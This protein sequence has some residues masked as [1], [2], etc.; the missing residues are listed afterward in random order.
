MDERTRILVC[1][2]ASVAS[3]CVSCFRH[4]AGKAEAA[5]VDPADVREAVTMGAQVKAGAHAILMAAV[6]A[7]T[8]RPGAAGEPSCC[9]PT[10]GGSCCP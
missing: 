2:S 7:Q 5:G 1:V 4:Y 6:D 10:P 8:G 9:G 3:N